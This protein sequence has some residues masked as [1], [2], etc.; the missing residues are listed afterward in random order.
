MR[1]FFVLLMAGM[2]SSCGVD[3]TPQ[4]AQAQA[5][6]MCAKD[7]DCKGDRICDSGQCKSP[8]REG[9]DSSTQPE[10]EANSDELAVTQSVDP[11]VALIE[12]LRLKPGTTERQGGTADA[13]M[14]YVNGGYVTKKPDFR[15]D[16]SDYRILKKPIR[17]MGH[18]LVVIDEEYMGEYVGCCVSHGVAVTV[19]LKPDGDNLDA[20]AKS[21]GCTLTKD[22]D[23]Y[24]R[25]IY[26]VPEAPKGTYATL[27]CK[28]RD[29]SYE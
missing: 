15:E 4:V 19:R 14:G 7:T 18:E 9:A 29:I 17:F 28:E 3:N 25:K 23:E 5:P 1:N 2:L 26:T 6:L 12:A 27:S 16:Y 21:N 8:D 22:T 24:F 10:M 20:F 13:V 11:Q